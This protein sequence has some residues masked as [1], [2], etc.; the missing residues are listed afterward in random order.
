MTAGTKFVPAVPVFEDL[1][2]DLILGTDFLLSDDI[3]ITI[4][5]GQVELC[6]STTLAQDTTAT[7]TPVP[8][9]TGEPA[10]LPTLPS[11]LARHASLFAK[12][13]ADL[14][15]TNL[16]VHRIPTG[17]HSPISV[18]LRRYAEQER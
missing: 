10:N 16:L 3:R 9:P 11:V 12:S 14:P 15:G 1:P 7:P 4:D 6:P 5:H 13:T 18:P 8:T 2:A 17:D